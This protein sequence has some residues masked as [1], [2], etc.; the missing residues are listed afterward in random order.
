M[1]QF[2]GYLLRKA[3]GKKVSPTIKS[4]K[5]TTDI[6][7][8]VKRVYRNEESKRIDKT[9]ASKEKMKAGKKMMREGQKELRR[10]I[11][12][13]RAFKFKNQKIGES[14]FATKPGENPKKK[15]KGLIE[16]DK[17]TKKFK[18]GKELAREKKMSGGMM[19]RRFGM[20]SGTPFKKET[21]VDKIKKTFSPKGK[22]LKPVDPKKQKGLA[23]LKQER[24]DVVRKMG[25]MKRGGRA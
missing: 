25:Y 2:V 18:T 14:T 10:Q 5:P 8:S 21:N 19:G 3:A 16:E 11:D 24:P 22:N 1:K 23:K 12:T 17:P 7:G 13:G 9:V 4:V 15:F 6:K 20:R